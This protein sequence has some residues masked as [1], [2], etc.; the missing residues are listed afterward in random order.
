ML[1]AGGSDTKRIGW[2]DFGFAQSTPSLKRNQFDKY[3]ADFS[4]Y[5][6][7]G[8]F[9]K[10]GLD[11]SYYGGDKL[12]RFSRYRPSFLGRPRIKGI[13]SGTDSFDDIGLASMSHGFNLFD[14]IKFEGSYNHAWARNKAES[15]HF[16]GFDG[17]EFDFGTA[18]PW[19]T[20]LQGTVTYALAG[21]LERYNSRWG[22]Y[23][24]IFRPLH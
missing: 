10:T 19:G 21:N 1:T 20:Y 15:N 6:Y 7:Y 13:P 18:G 17:L 24:L 11:L 12:D 16:R 2:K 8:K 5:F 3:Y 22:V 9:M 4:K 14:L 23:F